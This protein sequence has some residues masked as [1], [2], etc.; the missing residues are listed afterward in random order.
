MHNLSAVRIEGFNRRPLG[1]EDFYLICSKE[2]V[3]VLEQDVPTSFYLR[4]EGED[5]IVLRRGEKGLRRLFSAYHE[6][7][8]YFMHGGEYDSL[9]LFRGPRSSKSEIEADAFAAIALCP[10]IC[11]DNFDWLESNGE[12]FAPR[13]WLIRNMIWERYGI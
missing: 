11:L 5:V 9:A 8:H 7:G 10:R 1:E 4:C 3:A 12:R 2:K 13:V 6:L